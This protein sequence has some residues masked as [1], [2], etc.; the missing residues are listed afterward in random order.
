MYGPPVFDAARHHRRSIR[1]RGYDYTTPG[2]Y[3]VTF[4]TKERHGWFGKILEDKMILNANGRTAHEHWSAIPS[5]YQHVAVGAFV[6]MPDHVHGIVELTQRPWGSSISVVSDGPHGLVKGSLGAIV[7][8]YRAGVIRE[9]NRI[10]S[11][12]LRGVWQRGYHDIIVQ[13]DRV[14]RRMQEYIARHPAMVVQ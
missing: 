3:F 5:Y 8:A 4:C 14:L 11:Y 10:R 1:K 9:M 13:N 12:N 2:L 7:G 6:I